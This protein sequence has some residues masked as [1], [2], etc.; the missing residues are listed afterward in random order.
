[1]FNNLI[2]DVSAQISHSKFLLLADNLKNCQKIK[3]VENC[4]ALHADIARYNSGTLRTAGQ[5][6]LIFSHV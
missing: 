3:S 1:L 4:E 6:K 2:T 5:L